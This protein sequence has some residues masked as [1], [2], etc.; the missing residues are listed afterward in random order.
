M[1]RSEGF[2]ISTLVRKMGTPWEWATLANRMPFDTLRTLFYS[3]QY[4]DGHMLRE[5][6]LIREIQV[7]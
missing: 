2:G 4:S 5:I 6:G 3:S 7:K 1:G